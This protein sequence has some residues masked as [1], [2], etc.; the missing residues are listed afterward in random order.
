MS[1]RAL[2]ATAFAAITMAGAAPLAA[3]D[4]DY[5]EDYS[6]SK[7]ERYT[8]RVTT[9]RDDRFEG[10]WDDR[11]GCLPRHAIRDRLRDD[12]WRDIQR[13]EARGSK[14][15]LTAERPDGR[16]YDLKVDRCNGDIIDARKSRDGVYGEYRPRDRDYRY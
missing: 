10:T 9:H 2:A 12:G 13:I 3:A 1:A 16:L 7:T 4:L 5:P 14:V 11:R 15:F 8:E 6:Y